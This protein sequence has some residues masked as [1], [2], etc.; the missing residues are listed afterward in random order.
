MRS[1]LHIYIIIISLLELGCSDGIKQTY[2]SDKSKNVVKDISVLYETVSN[3]S[4]VFNK[5][6]ANTSLDLIKASILNVES[7]IIFKIFEYR[8]KKAQYICR[9]N[10]AFFF[11]L[12]GTDITLDEI[13]P[14]LIY[15]Y[16]LEKRKLLE[17]WVGKFMFSDLTGDLMTSANEHIF[18][19]NM[20]NSFSFG[21]R[22]IFTKA[23]FGDVN[24]GVFDLFIRRFLVEG[25]LYL[26][27]LLSK[28]I[29]LDCMDPDFS[30]SALVSK[31]KFIFPGY[32]LKNPH[33]Q[34]YILDLYYENDFNRDL[35]KSYLKVNEKELQNQDI[36][37]STF[38]AVWSMDKSLRQEKPMTFQLINTLLFLF[39]IRAHDPEVY[40]F[41][42]SYREVGSYLHFID[43]FYKHYESFNGHEDKNKDNNELI[44]YFAPLAD[45][46]NNIKL[47][48]T[49]LNR[50]DHR[51]IMKSLE[52]IFDLFISYL[53]PIH[54]KRLEGLLIEEKN[55]QTMEY[56][57][58][59][60]ASIEKHCKTLRRIEDFSNISSKKEV[61]VFIDTKQTE[62]LRDV[63]SYL[64]KNLS[65][66]EDKYLK[67]RLFEQSLEVLVKDFDFEEFNFKTLDYK[68]KI[69]V[70]LKIA[71]EK[72][73]IKKF[74]PIYEF[75]LTKLLSKNPELIISRFYGFSFEK[76]DSDKCFDIMQ[77]SKKN[78]NAWQ[79][80][81]DEIYSN[82]NIDKIS[83]ETLSPF[84]KESISDA[85]YAV[86]Y[87]VL[88]FNKVKPESEKVDLTEFQKIIYDENEKKIELKTQ[89]SIL[90]SLGK[91]IVLIFLQ[92][93]H[94]ELLQNVK[95]HTGISLLERQNKLMETLKEIEN[96]ILSKYKIADINL[97]E[98]F[99]SSEKKKKELKQKK[100]AL[101]RIKLDEIR[102]NK[103]DK[104]FKIFLSKNKDYKCEFFSS[105]RKFDKILILRE[106]QHLLSSIIRVNNSLNEE[107]EEYDFKLYIASFFKRIDEIID[108]YYTIV[109]TPI[110]NQFGAILGLKT[111]YMSNNSDEI[112][113]SKMNNYEVFYS[114]RA[115]FFFS[116]MPYPMLD[117]DIKT[118][119]ELLKKENSSILFSLDEIKEAM[120]DRIRT[121]FFKKEINAFYLDTDRGIHIIFEKIEF[122]EL[123]KLNFIFHGDENYLLS[124]FI[125]KS[126][127]KRLSQ[128]VFDSREGGG[129]MNVVKSFCELKK[130][131]VSLFNKDWTLGVNSLDL[132][133][134]K[135]P[136]KIKKQN[137]NSELERYLELQHKII[138]RFVE[139]FNEDSYEAF[140]KHMKPIKSIDKLSIDLE[141][142][143]KEF[144]REKIFKF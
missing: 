70:F 131:Y 72:K 85:I 86:I 75:F 97:E 68:G 45:I 5:E 24:S 58:L 17:L 77:F 16:I 40:W 65:V 134:N 54:L 121:Y 29:I 89:V 120:I 11:F 81:F 141:M 73:P 1:R 26:R 41:D 125:E 66:A 112:L 38:A 35:I 44:E 113:I 20:S 63:I 74:K 62:E 39:E 60:R 117:L 27:P 4:F 110:Y 123:L 143:L 118:F 18:N 83:F 53:E 37:F 139:S 22:Y 95:E 126:Y 84:I 102:L 105:L 15:K 47:T 116:K 127:K 71:N 130:E 23:Y 109:E 49:E 114:K 92:K 122:L 48:T 96:P 80:F 9:T 34:H 128:K 46:H 104:L 142:R 36:N 133:N 88:N 87:N 10:F 57:L 132:V 51:V 21:I 135:K 19:K 93:K 76:K 100:E 103:I 94:L 55:D 78:N 99:Y 3:S 2:N 108:K 42:T 67:E 124:S 64:V 137:P 144:Y 28:T 43:S 140:W 31:L 12:D 98:V 13:L 129:Y 138:Y 111:E 56:V 25:E 52:E 82:L 32:I 30:Q 14:Y 106:K 90:Q 6:E 59:H 107:N 50:A 33:Y 91:S 101:N 136:K 61:E 115:G 69:I 79:T 8:E 7:E 119:V